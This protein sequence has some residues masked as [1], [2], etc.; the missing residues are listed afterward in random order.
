MKNSLGRFGL[1]AV[2]GTVLSLSLGA[3]DAFAIV[4]T[5]DD[6]PVGA[7]S[8]A[9]FDASTGEVTIDR[10]GMGFVT[11]DEDGDGVGDLDVFLL[12]VTP[13]LD[14]PFGEG[15]GE[16]P[17]GAHNAGPGDEGCDGVG[18]DDLEACAGE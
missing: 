12:P 8:A 4:C 13:G 10:P 1:A 7:G 11:I 14:D 6:K 2:A 5:V 3:G 16:L 15:L 9:T 18:I 17:D